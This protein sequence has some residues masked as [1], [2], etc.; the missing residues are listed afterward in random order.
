MENSS[1]NS[2]MDLV[3]RNWA[4]LPEWH[5][6]VGYD[7]RRRLLGSEQLTPPPVKLLWVCSRCSGW[8]FLLMSYK[9]S[10]DPGVTPS[11]GRPKSSCHIQWG[12]RTVIQSSMKRESGPRGR[13]QT[14]PSM[15]ER[16]NLRRPTS[17]QLFGREKQKR[18]GEPGD[19][20]E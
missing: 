16:K 1:W 13:R 14:P 3:T 10:A 4:L 5:S 2:H 18:R 9:R 17:T 12:V 19:T 15:P 8:C 7:K 20:K 6:L 11:L